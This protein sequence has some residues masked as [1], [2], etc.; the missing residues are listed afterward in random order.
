MELPELLTLDIRAMEALLAN[1][2]LLASLES[3]EMFRNITDDLTA[4]ISTNKELRQKTI[5]NEKPHSGKKAKKDDAAK[6]RENLKKR[7]QRFIT[8]IP[9][10]MYLTD[11][12]EDH[13]RRHQVEPELFEKVTG[14]TLTDFGQLV[15]AGVFNDAKMNDA[16][17]VP[18]VRESSL[19]YGEES[20]RCAPR[21]LELLRRRR[22]SA[23]LIDADVLPIGCVL[24]GTNGVTPASAIITDDSGV[25][26][27]GI[28]YESPDAAAGSSHQWCS[29]RRVGVLAGNHRIRGR[30]PVR[31]PGTTRRRITPPVPCGPASEPSWGDQGCGDGAVCS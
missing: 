19:H 14:L 26:V 21:R 16:G 13:Q 3:I 18:H 25:A 17:V 30:S 24:T 31:T 5:T 27:G 20:P 2:D 11:D 29:Q 6:K 1:P 8:R 7:L 22:A 9:A 4:M 10:F 23:R 28:R 12:R 15:D